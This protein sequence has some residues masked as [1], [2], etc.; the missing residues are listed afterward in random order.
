MEQAWHKNKAIL[1]TGANGPLARV[2]INR[3]PNAS[4]Y[5]L[6]SD[7]YRPIDGAVQIIGDPRDATLLDSLSGE[8]ST[9]V[10]L[11]PICDTALLPQERL[12][13]T[14]QGT[15]QLA[16]SF[17]EKTP[18]GRFILAS[19]GDLFGT[20]WTQ[21]RINERW[22]PRPTPSQSQLFPYLAEQSLREVARVTGLSAICLRMGEIVDESASLTENPDPR[23]LHANDAVAA[24]AC[25]IAAEHKGWGIYHI[26]ARGEQAAID[27]TLAKEQLSYNPSRGFDTSSG[28]GGGQPAKSTTIPVM[29]RAIRTV[30]IFGAGG[31]LGSAIT[32]ELSRDYELRLSDVKPLDE[33]CSA[34]PQSAGAP[35]PC[36]PQ[37]P[38][39]WHTVDIRDI[40]QV[41]AACADADA[42]INC[43]VA[44]Y[45]TDAAFGVNMVGAYNVMSAAVA[46]GIHRVVHT[47][48][49]MLGDR[50]AF[51]YD[52]DYSVVDDVPPRP[53]IDW[54]Y[55]PSKLAG[56]EI[57]RV[58][59]EFYGMSVPVLAFCQFVNPENGAPKCLHPL[60]VSWADAARAARAA[61][62]VEKMPHPYEYFHIGADLP[63]GVYRVDKARQLLNWVAKDSLEVFYRR[64]EMQASHNGAHA[65]HAGT[66]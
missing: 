40:E 65:I 42:I 50:G 11:E 13:H 7:F 58:F 52:W 60:A 46:Q 23:W 5:A 8:I 35:L 29:P 36:R 38:H 48:P 64:P 43:A 10:H 22:R 49:F 32:A 14:V 25:A 34:Q 56:Q 44:R 18:N 24:I 16:M 19:T 63:H 3:L 20:L 21:Y 59:A 17:A 57:C 27:S 39:I 31:P 9:I 41:K 62:K 6:D 2:L 47:G 54:V 1:I 33:L 12:G 61:L 53:G 4:I 55:I 66:M 51:G 37:S 15:Y 30:A 26:G 45:G 28:S